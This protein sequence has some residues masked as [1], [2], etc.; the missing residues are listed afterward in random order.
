VALTAV[1]DE[2]RDAVR[3]YAAGLETRRAG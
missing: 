3:R 2:T 1:W